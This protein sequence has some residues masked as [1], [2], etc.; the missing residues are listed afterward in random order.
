MKFKGE[1]VLDEQEVLSAVDNY[2][3]PQLPDGLKNKHL[4]IEVGSRQ[5]KYF[6]TIALE[7]PK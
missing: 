1:I 7:E 2:V 4:I 3:R 6:A 5:G